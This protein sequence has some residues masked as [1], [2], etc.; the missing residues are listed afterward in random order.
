MKIQILNCFT[1]N[2]RFP[3]E[4]ETGTVCLLVETDQGLTLVDTGLGLDDYAHPTWFTQFFRIIT[5]MPFD[6]QEA[7]INQIQRLGY[8]PED[9][10]H[11]ILT[12]MHFDHCG[13]LPDFPHAVSFAWSLRRSDQNRYGMA[14]SLCRCGSGFSEDEHPCMDDSVRSWP[15][16]ASP[17]KV[18]C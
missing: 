13:G 18:L 11:I 17:A 5:S 7:A 1:C 16:H 10:K 14:F 4:L 8:K 15:I 12:H 2:A 6:P 3:R 9:L